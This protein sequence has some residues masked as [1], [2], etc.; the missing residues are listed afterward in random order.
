MKN[1]EILGEAGHEFLNSQNKHFLVQQRHFSFYCIRCDS[2][3]YKND[4]I[5]SIKRVW[6]E[7]VY[8]P[9]NKMSHAGKFLLDV[10]IRQVSHTHGDKRALSSSCHITSYLTSNLIY[11]RVSKVQRTE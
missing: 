4:A 2:Q 9:G 10:N 5:Q 8:F 7:D 6:E 1:P 11:W 3:S